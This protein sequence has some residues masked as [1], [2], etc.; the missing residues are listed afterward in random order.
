MVD[1]LTD[2]W[3][4]DV[5]IDWLTDLQLYLMTHSLSDYILVTN[6][7]LNEKT[8]N[9]TNWLANLL[10]WLTNSLANLLTKWLKNNWLPAHNLDFSDN[11]IMTDSLTKLLTTC[12]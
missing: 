3:F 9:N 2:N 10:Y 12:W 5:P 8:E 7:A 11:C 1:F 4:T 6:I